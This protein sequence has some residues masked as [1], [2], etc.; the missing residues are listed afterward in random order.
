MFKLTWWWRS[1]RGRIAIVFGTYS[2]LM[3]LA[4]LVNYCHVNKITQNF[5]FLEKCDSFLN[6]IL[7]IRRYEK[8]FLLYYEDKS[9]K[10]ALYYLQ[11][12]R[13]FLKKNK[14]QIRYFIGEKTY[15]KL[16]NKI[17]EYQKTFE[18]LFQKNRRVS[19]FAQMTLENRLRELGH[20]LVDIASTIDKRVK[21][22]IKTAL[23]TSRNV[24]IFFT[25]GTLVCLGLLIYITV[26]RIIGPLTYIQDSTEQIIKGNYQIFPKPKDPLEEISNLI[27]ALN[28]MIQELEL[29]KEQLIQSRK[30]ASLGTFTAGIAHEIN[31][32]LNNIYLTAEAFLEEFGGSL[33]S[34]QK[35]YVIDILNQ[36]QRASDIVANLLDF[37]R[38]KRYKIGQVNIGEIINNVVKICQN[39]LKINNVKLKLNIP[40][41]LP[42]IEGDPSSLRQVFINLIENAVQAMPNGGRLEI[43]AEA[44]NSQ[45][46]IKVTDTGIGIPKTNL[47]R[48]FEPFF[49]T[50]GKGT[51]LGLAVT[52]GIIE[53]HGGKIKV[54]SEVKKGTTFTIILPIKKDVK[55][56]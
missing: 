11:K 8:N 18:E 40:S 49:T 14:D 41:S 29:R 42:I 30:M 15:Q 20:T 13:R 37:S 38:T 39:V 1:V 28:K 25:I 12:V 19:S 2:L 36:V 52:Y 31:N 35:E 5:I 24:P 45:L 16:A 3:I 34:G 51:G 54:E 43:S 47:N 50:K 44:D 26:H 33:T 21:I 48:I 53:K 22:N 27:D 17:D 9:Y 23:F 56:S 46:K 10:S 32:P 4:G 6:D 7:E 55:Q